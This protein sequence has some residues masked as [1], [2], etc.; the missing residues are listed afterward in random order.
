MRN[1]GPADVESDKRRVEAALAIR[2]YPDNLSVCASILDTV[3]SSA[4][5]TRSIN[6]KEGQGECG[7]DRFAGNRDSS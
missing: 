6:K 1:V 2:S 4:A 3:G 7:R 5:R